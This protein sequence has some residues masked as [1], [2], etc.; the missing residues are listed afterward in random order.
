MY[1]FP[2]DSPINTILSPLTIFD[3]LDGEVYH[4]RDKNGFE[5]DAQYGLIEIKIGGSNLISEGAASLKKLAFVID[6]KKMKVPSFALVL[7]GIG[8]YAYKR[9]DGVLVV[10]VGC[11]RD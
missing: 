2:N 7:T 10:P 11:L 9:E 1:S 4:F 3:K 6:T 5:C 8:R